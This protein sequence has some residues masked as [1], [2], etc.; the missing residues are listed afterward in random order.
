MTVVLTTSTRV[1]GRFLSKELIPQEFKGI[2]LATAITAV[3]DVWRFYKFEIGRALHQH[4]KQ[5]TSLLSKI[6]DV[7]KARF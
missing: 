1:I 4:R 7:R 2:G 6:I 3:C 5:L